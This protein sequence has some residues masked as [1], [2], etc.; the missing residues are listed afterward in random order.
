M[1]NH[2]QALD[3][4]FELI[5]LPGASG[6]T[7]FWHP[8]M[9]ALQV[10][11][12]S[13][14][15]AYPGFADQPSHTQVNGFEDLQR[16]V[17]AQMIPSMPPTLKPTEA[18]AQKRIIVAQS[19]GGIFA[20]QTALQ[21]PMQVDGLVLVATSGGIDLSNFEVLDWRQSYLKDLDVPDWFAITQ[22]QGVA[23]ALPEIRC[24][25]LLIWGDA[26]PISPV[27]VGQYL[28][29]QF[30]QAELNIIAGGE[31]NLANVHADQ[32]SVLISD[33]LEKLLLK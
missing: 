5:Y 29:Q 14:V 10:K 15:I 13:R 23:E 17:I 33:F 4:L 19:M 28:Q 6:N 2:A 27:A 31:H 12:D 7:Q 16:Y 18:V 11:A 3:M 30:V 26:D 32:V 1:S 24:P 9:Q 8:V 21:H 20:V 22:S 25:V